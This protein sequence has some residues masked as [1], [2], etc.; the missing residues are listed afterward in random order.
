MRSGSGAARTDVMTFNA[1]QEP[2]AVALV[3]EREPQPV[4][5]I[6]STVAVAELAQAQGARL[7]ELWG[8]MQ[9]RGVAPLGPPFVRYHTFAETETDVEL[10]FPVGP[11]V[12]GSGRIEAGQLPGGAAIVTWHFGAHDSLG[13]AYRRLEGWLETNDREA[14]GSAWEV[15]WWIDPGREPDPSSWP[16]PTEWRTELVQPVGLAVGGEA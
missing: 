9:A 6:R 8:S 7:S 15:Y 16:A 11:G 12:A 10:G 14:G 4:L 2:E 13:D 1:P 3:E 5:S